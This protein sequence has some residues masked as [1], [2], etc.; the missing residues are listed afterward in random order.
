MIHVIPGSPSC[1]AVTSFEDKLFVARAPN[2]ILVYDINTFQLLGNIT[3]PGAAGFF[4]GLGACPINNCLYVS[5]WSKSVVYKVDL[6]SD[7]FNNPRITNKSVCNHPNGLSVNS[8]H[9]LMV[10][11]Y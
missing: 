5:D 4:Y 2:L 1:T 11:V 9:N 10:T 3:V 7:I 6:S 8:Q